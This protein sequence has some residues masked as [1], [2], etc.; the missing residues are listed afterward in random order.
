LDTSL[1]GFASI[2]NL[3]NELW[4]Q[5]FVI[6]RIIQMQELSGLGASLHSIDLIISQKQILQN[7]GDQTHMNR[8][9]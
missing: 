9:S 2:A 5:E 4:R 8:L 3:T 6:A 1:C 7:L